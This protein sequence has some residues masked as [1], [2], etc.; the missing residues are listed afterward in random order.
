MTNNDLHDIKL[1]RINPLI[2]LRQKA[3]VG[4]NTRGYSNMGCIKNR[5]KKA[6]K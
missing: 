5:W 3:K 6:G 1:N 2:N 4:V